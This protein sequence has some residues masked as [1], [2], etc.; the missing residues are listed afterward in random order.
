MKAIGY[1]KNLPIDNPEALVDIEY[2]K[3]NPG[4]RDLLVS[5]K[6]VSVNPVDV[7]VR[8]GRAPTDGEP[9][10]LGWDAAGIVEAVGKEVS[11]FKAGD[12]VWYAGAINRPGSN[13]EFQLVDERI[14]G[15]MPNSLSYA[16]AAALPLTSI[17][18]WE[19]L[20]DRLELNKTDIQGKTLMI[21]GAAGGVGSILIPLAKHLTSLTIIATASRPETQQWVKALGAD[22]AINHNQPLSKELIKIGKSEVDYIISLNTEPHFSEIVASIKPQGKLVVLDEPKIDIMALKSKSASLHWEFMFTRSLYQTEDQIKQHELLDRIAEL[23]DEGVIKTTLAKNLGTI[24]AKNLR[25]AHTLIESEKTIGK[26][27]L[28]DF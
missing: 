23:I 9:Q 6:A 19:L 20:F 1:Y 12:K 4:D 22:F 10:I 18:A 13:S 11:L 16:Q 25:E 21:I 17:T 15:H 27:V 7:K 2:P 26:I 5:V 8:N 3:P 14:V 24:N 28:E